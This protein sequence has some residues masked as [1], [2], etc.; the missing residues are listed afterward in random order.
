MQNMQNKI[1]KQLLQ[2]AEYWHVL[3]FHILHTY[4]L[5]F[6]DG[7]ARGIWAHPSVTSWA[8]C[9]P[10]EKTNP[11]VIMARLPASRLSTWDSTRAAAPA[12]QVLSLLQPAFKL[13]IW[14]TW[15]LFT[16]KE[17]SFNDILKLSDI[18]WRAVSWN[19]GRGEILKLLL[20][21]TQGWSQGHSLS[22][23]GT[24]R[25]YD[26]IYGIPIYR[27]QSH[28]MIWSTYDIIDV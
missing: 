16:L 27:Y 11:C 23:S 4:A 21:P 28:P 24:V 14:K 2:Y 12:V 6:A 10:S 3:I 1:C 13:L 17:L 18:R 26:I 5:Y 7:R 9:W 22:A 15:G 8:W 19:D 25:Y 20:L